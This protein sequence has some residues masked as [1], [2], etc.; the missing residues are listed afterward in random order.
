[1]PQGSFLPSPSPYLFVYSLTMRHL[2]PITLMYLLIWL[3]TFYVINRSSP[4]WPQLP[5]WGHSLPLGLL[6]LGS[7]HP[8]TLTSSSLHMDCEIPYCSHP[9]WSF[10]NSMSSPCC[11]SPLWHLAVL[12]WIVTK[13]KGHNRE[14]G[15]EKRKGN[16][17]FFKV[18]K[19]HV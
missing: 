4:A 13:E 8:P 2:V 6:F 10:P 7:G 15:K 1:M 14:K 11:G 3:I 17:S 18:M 16:L 19:I 5:C 9:M 12:D